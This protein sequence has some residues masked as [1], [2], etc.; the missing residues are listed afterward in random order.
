MKI[1][2]L[3]VFPNNPQEIGKQH[4]PIDSDLLDQLSAIDEE[5][6]KN[7]QKP[8]VTFK[9]TATSLIGRALNEDDKHDVMI[10]HKKKQALKHKEKKRIRERTKELDKV[11]KSV[12]N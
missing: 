12:C 3:N 11:T 10:H 6:T 8:I 5:Y 9:E 1:K 4:T 7:S 2:N